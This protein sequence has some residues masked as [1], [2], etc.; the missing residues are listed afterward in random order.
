MTK[1]RPYLILPA[2]LVTCSYYELGDP[3]TKDTIIM[4][5]NTMRDINTFDEF[6]IAARKISKDVGID[7]GN[8]LYAYDYDECGIVSY[9]TNKIAI[10]LRN[11]EKEPYISGYSYFVNKSGRSI[12]FLRKGTLTPVVLPA[13]EDAGFWYGKN[14]LFTT[15]EGDA[16]ETLDLIDEI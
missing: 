9:Q 4:L 6:R 10:S 15:L 1:I 13:D 2:I 5:A 8:K 7:G 11:E 16:A 3:L 12:D 14:L